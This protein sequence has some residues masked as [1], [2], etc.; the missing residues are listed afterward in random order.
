MY[1]HLLQKIGLTENESKVYIA[2]IKAGNS[3]SSTIISLANISG[4]KI[5]ETLDK[6][7]K[8]GFISIS[9][10][11]RVKHFQ[12]TNPES[13]INYI[14]EQKNDLNEKE[15]EFKKIIPEIKLLKKE[16]TFSSEIIIGTKGIKPLIQELFRNSKEPILAMGIRGDK[17]ETYNNFWWHLTNEEIEKKNKKAKYLFIENKSNYFKKHEKLK[18][19]HV[20]VLKSISPAAIDIIDDHIIFLTYEDDELHCVHIQS[21]PIANSFKSFFNNLWNQSAKQ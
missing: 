13:I 1:E 2:I 15:K 18:N 7:Y 20:R 12:A 10:I 21:K 16:N 4:G 5:Y 14:E 11:N 19:I 9:N 6:L 17:K 8:K 3:T